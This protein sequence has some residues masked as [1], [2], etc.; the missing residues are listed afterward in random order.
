MW[1]FQL[2]IFSQW[3]FG[4]HLFVVRVLAGT[5]LVCVV[6][7]LVVSAMSTVQVDADGLS[8]RYRWLTRRTGLQRRWDW[9]S[10]EAVNEGSGLALRIQGRW[11]PFLPVF[12]Q[13]SR[14]RPGLL[15][16][17]ETVRMRAVTRGIPALHPSA[18]THF[19][20]NTL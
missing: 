16:F 11:L 17:G 19:R 7:V 5:Y 3:A 2:A 14:N 4:D 1:T 20:P 6:P 13:W 10:I 9:S 12:L 15:A 8:V 18:W